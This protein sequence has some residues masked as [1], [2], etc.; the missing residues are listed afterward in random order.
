MAVLKRSDGLEKKTMSPSLAP[1]S[2]EKASRITSTLTSG[3]P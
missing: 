3:M 1:A 2:R